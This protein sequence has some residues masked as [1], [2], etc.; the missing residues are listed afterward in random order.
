[1]A[2]FNPEIPGLEKKS[3]IAVPTCDRLC[4]SDKKARPR[5]GRGGLV[6]VVIIR[7]DERCCVGEIKFFFVLKHRFYLFFISIMSC[8]CNYYRTRVQYL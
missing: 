5:D 4:T 7:V 2:F 3:G 6:G 8:A 1:L